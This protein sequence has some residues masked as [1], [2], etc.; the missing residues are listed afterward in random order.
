M[1]QMTLSTGSFDQYAKTTRRAVFLAEM[2]RVVPW[3]QL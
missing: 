1:K 3:K 2:N